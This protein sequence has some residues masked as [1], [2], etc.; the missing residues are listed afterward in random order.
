MAPGAA[1]G[2]IGWRR[3]RVDC[4][5]LADLG[6]VGPV[7]QWAV[8]SY[9]FVVGM[10]ATVNPCGA[11]MLPAYLTWFTRSEPGG[12]VP[13]SLRVPRA[14][15]SGLAAT[16]GFVVV[17]AVVGA[18]VSAGLGAVMSATPYAGIAV[19]AALVVVGAL[20]VAG[21]HVALR[22]PGSTRNLGGGGGGARSMAGFG[23]SYALASLGCT[24]PVFLAGVAGAFTRSGVGAGIAAFVSFALGMGAVLTALAVAIAVAPRSRLRGVRSLGSRLERPA[25]LL[26]V[27]VGAYLVY[28][29]AADL[30]GTQ[31]GTGV[32][33][34]VDGAAGAVASA[35]G[36]AGPLL[37][38]GLVGAVAAAVFLAS[39]RG[40]P[41]GPGAGGNGE[42]ASLPVPGDG[43]TVVPHPVPPGR[44]PLLAGHPRV[45]RASPFL[46]GGLAAGVLIA[47]VGDGFLSGGAAG[48]A[49]GGSASGG[50]SASAWA[51]RGVDPATQRLISLDPIP[52]TQRT[53]PFTLTDQRGRRESLS[54]FR[55]EAVI[56]TFNDNHCTTLCP[57]YAAD[58]RAA[59]ADLGSLAHRV[60]FVA[61]NVNPFYPAVAYDVAFDREHG[62]DRVPD[63][64]YL[65][66]SLPELR[67]VWKAYGATPIIGPD[68]SVTHAPALWLIGPSGHL[69]GVADYGPSSA[70]STLW[71]HALA[72][73]AQALLGT[74]AHLPSV[75]VSAP[76]TPPS[77]APGFSMRLLGAAPGSRVSLASLRG[78]PLVLNFFASWCSACQAEAS[79]LATAARQLP[80]GVRLVGVDVGDSASAAEKFVRRYQL[81]YP[82]GEDPQGNVAG[83]YGIAGL[84]TTVFVSATGMI[85]D[86]HVGVITPAELSAGAT[87]LLGRG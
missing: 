51:A 22:L 19:G 11:A 70:D 5:V 20:S 56:L 55:G 63:W 77:A 74:H 66:G 40:T 64:H 21:R 71:G 36:S 45:R 39:I 86:R 87:R 65:T 25:G 52:G 23:I 13:V 32:I 9:A 83:S 49:T 6:S 62:L 7:M 60:A 8:L 47:V 43:P 59:A 79:G 29:W 41:P 78:H 85:V 14:V 68:R 37:G 17:F 18:A 15:L 54:S 57:L 46:A 72:S 69:R 4:P 84:P 38:V 82:V 3:T 61:V 44:K 58:V 26:L 27:A 2:L 67:A 76:P 30:S 16:A 34:A 31:S 10:A 81:P 75:T 24:L 35:F 48:P 28:Y 73:V 33:G 53:P 80:A 12:E 50:A 1:P 42:P